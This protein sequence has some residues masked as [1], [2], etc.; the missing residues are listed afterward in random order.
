METFVTGLGSPEC[1]IVLDNGDLL[2]VEMTGERRAVTRV[3]ANT[4]ELVVVH[5]TGGQP[6]GLVRDR[7][8]NLW[9][10]EAFEHA[11][12]KLDAEGS[13]LLRITRHGDEEF[14]WPN[15]LVIGPHDAIYFTDSG[16]WQRELLSPTEAALLPI[17]K[18]YPY[19]GRVYRIDTDTL[20]VT[21]LD[22]GLRFTNGLAFGPD[23]LLYVNETIGGAIYR[24]DT[25][26]H[27]PKREFFG[28]VFAG[29]VP[30]EF[31]GPDGMKFGADGRLYCTVTGQGELA[32]LDKTGT[33]VERIKTAGI[34]PTNI[35]F[36]EDGRRKAYVTEVSNGAVEIH[37]M[38]C[39]GLPLHR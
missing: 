20:A 5:E 31:I 4:R 25:T 19:D 38:P 2:L 35:A 16:A 6:N 10:G 27:D 37:D 9:V 22:N 7:H 30:T 14:R 11:I 26:V 29:E 13:E 1:P 21:R 3:D 36:T 24:Y 23:G 32:V 17:W 18:D 33:V 34:A 28:N 12:I 39:D 15:D 8:G